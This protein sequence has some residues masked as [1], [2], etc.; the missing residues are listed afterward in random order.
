MP[1]INFPVDPVSSSTP[2][3]SS[4]QEGSQVQAALSDT[5]D[6]PDTAA[7]TS[8]SLQ[9]EHIADDPV[10]TTEVELQK[11]A[12]E[13]S[14]VV[15]ND[16]DNSTDD[17]DE[18]PSVDTSVAGRDIDEDESAVSKEMV[19]RIEDHEIVQVRNP[20]CWCNCTCV[21]GYRLFKRVS[22]AALE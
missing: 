17:G 3:V 8:S 2:E 18:I 11:E 6:L 4:K 22:N 19:P 16:P 7:P 1:G 9:S 21:E 15:E 20:M 14:I 12:E 10:V 5:N 13:I